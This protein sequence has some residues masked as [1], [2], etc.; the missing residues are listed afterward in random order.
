MAETKS[1]FQ[2]C[3]GDMPSLKIYHLLSM[4]LIVLLIMLMPITLS[5]QVGLVLLLIA[6]GWFAWPQPEHLSFDARLSQQ[7]G[8]LTL[9]SAVHLFV[10]WRVRLQ[11][12]KG[13]RLVWL[14]DG[15][16]NREEQRMLRV[17][18]HLEQMKQQAS[19]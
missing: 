10:G 14:F 9:K 3:P 18:S 6:Y 7:Q 13:E 17:A 11:D 19:I 8:H 1:S 2:I 12:D 16:L 4:A 5:G 15:Q